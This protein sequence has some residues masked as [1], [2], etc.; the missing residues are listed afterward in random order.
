MNVD[1]IKYLC[2]YR[3]DNSAVGTREVFFLE[4]VSSDD[5]SEIARIKSKNRDLAIDAIVD[6]KVDEYENRSESL[7]K[8]PGIDSGENLNSNYITPVF[9]KTKVSPKKFISYRDCYNK[10]IDHIESSTQVSNQPDLTYTNN[11]NYSG[12]ENLDM[13]F[14][15]IITKINHSSNAIAF[16]GRIGTANCVLIGRNILKYMN[17]N[18]YFDLNSNST[19]PDFIGSLNGI[20]VL[21]SDRIADDKIVVL[22]AESDKNDSGLIFIENKKTS[23]YYFTQTD[24]AFDKA[25]K[26]FRVS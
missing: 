22:R 23:E 26:Y 21:V 9:R 6:D 12:S 7:H 16:E 2:S 10:I 15:R 14:R 17:Q 18:K 11:S 8:W 3:E 1:D 19:N 25:F 13:F 24:K 4:M 20:S 5:P